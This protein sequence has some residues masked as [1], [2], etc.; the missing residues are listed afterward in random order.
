MV[1]LRH[2]GILVKIK[3]RSWCGVM[4]Y[5]TRLLTFNLNYYLS[6]YS[7]F[8]SYL[9]HATTAPVRYVSST[10]NIIQTVIAFVIEE[11]L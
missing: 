3:E 10:I 6:L 2:S 1:M 11:T 5:V 8:V 7:T 9:T 4:E